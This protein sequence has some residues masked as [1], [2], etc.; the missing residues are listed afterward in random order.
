MGNTVNLGKLKEE[1]DSRKQSKNNVVLNTNNGETVINRP[2]DGF[3]N[4]LL[5][6]LNTGVKTDASRV[7]KLVENKAA[8]KMGETRKPIDDTKFNEIKKQTILE[9]K[10]LVNENFDDIG[11]EEQMYKE[12]MK[13]YTSNQFPN[14][15]NYQNTNNQTNNEIDINK[16]FDEV[17]NKLSEQFDSKII[18]M[19]SYDR[20]KRVLFENK[21][22]IKEIV[23]EV[24]KE[25][26]A[27]K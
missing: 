2:K 1:I 22:L 16:I 26:R 25:L 13:K 10:P 18:E 3:L 14:T 20:I 4:Q 8:E 9:R 24:I 27:K 17:S 7:V 6:S 15:V 21:D 5:T 12:M 19:Y 11:R 23:I